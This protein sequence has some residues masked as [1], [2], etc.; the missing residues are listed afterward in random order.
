MFRNILV[1]LD[2]Y[3]ASEKAIPLAIDVATASGAHLHLMHVMDFLTMPPYARSISPQAWWSGKGG[4]LARDYVERIA[5]HIRSTSDLEVSVAVRSSAVVPALLAELRDRHIDLIVMGTHARSV[6]GRMWLGSV[7]EPM[8]RA[9]LCPILLK[10][11][12]EHLPI[13]ESTR[14]RKILVPLDGSPTAE[15]AL[16]SAAHLAT[17]MQAKVTLLHVLSMAPMVTPVFHFGYDAPTMPQYMPINEWRSTAEQ[18]L[19]NQR[20]K[21][22]MQTGLE[23]ETDVVLKGA[24]AAEDVISYA[25]RH[26]V[27]VIAMATHGRSGIK[28]LVLGSTTEHVLR[29]SLLPLLVVP[30]H[31]RSEQDASAEAHAHA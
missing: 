14:V 27:D 5:D 3:P 2:A 15:A 13:R 12:P 23:V 11:V 22:V 21:L 17:A 26:A 18:Y 31:V 20:D 29:H 9:S 4:N 8:M 6:V 10:R 30:P 28:R 16:D 25:T 19:S 7:A 24:L 1:P